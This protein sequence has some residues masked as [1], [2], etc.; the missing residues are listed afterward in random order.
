MAAHLDATLVHRDPDIL[1]GVPVFTGTRVP[2]KAL[3]DYLAA[4]HSLEE[5]VDDFPSVSLER[6]RQVLDMFQEI[7]LDQPYETAA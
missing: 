1:G 5:F 3:L 2:V 6:A 4:G 7:L